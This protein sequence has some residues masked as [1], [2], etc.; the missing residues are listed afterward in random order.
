MFGSLDEIEKANREDIVLYL[1]SW[2]IACY[3]NESTCLLRAA[4]MDTFE[5]EGC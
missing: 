1:E 4:A 3:D 5:T 2:G